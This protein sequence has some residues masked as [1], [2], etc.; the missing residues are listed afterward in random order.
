MIRT[1]MR[2]IRPVLSSALMVQDTT[3]HGRRYRSICICQAVLGGN[4]RGRKKAGRW[5][6]E[7]PLPGVRKKKELEEIF[8]RTYGK[9][10]RKR[11][12]GWKRQVRSLDDG[13]KK[14]KDPAETEYLLVDGYNVIF[15]WE[16][17]KELAR[18][19]S[20]G[21][22]QADGCALQLSGIPGLPGDPGV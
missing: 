17:L 14:K 3:C 2:K 8:I 11:Q 13:E 5:R 10:E 21:Q 19:I 18:S 12:D 9:V 22:A 16:D 6:D 7:R 15:A 1:G 4:R 20:R